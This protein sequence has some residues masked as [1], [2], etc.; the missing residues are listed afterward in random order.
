MKLEY[1]LTLYTTINSKWI[2]GLNG[3]QENIKLPEEN[4]GGTFFDINR[5]NNLGIC[6][7]KQKKQNQK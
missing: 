7:L 3:K 2:K 4:I 5:S 1:S 6:L